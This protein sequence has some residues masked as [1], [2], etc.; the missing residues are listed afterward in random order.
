MELEDE[1]IF[2]IALFTSLLGIMGMIITSSYIM[3][4]KV[5]IKD[6]GLGMVDK[7]VSVE[8]FVQ[9][10]EKSKKGE[11]YFVDINDGNGRIKVVV[12]QSTSLDLEKNNISMVGLGQRRVNVVG[13][14]A[15]YQGNLEIILKDS[16][17]LK[18]LA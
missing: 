17:S 6:I 16:K 11:T 9:G 8:G 10:V 3:P 13:S 12:F 4:H 2:K 15:E 1:K 7:E 5:Q 18:I 14:V